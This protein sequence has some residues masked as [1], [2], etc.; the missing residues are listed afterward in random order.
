MKTATTNQTLNSL[1]LADKKAYE[2]YLKEV[3]I[4]YMPYLPLHLCVLHGDIR[5][6]KKYIAAGYDLNT[7]DVWGRTVVYYAIFNEDIK[8]LK[9]LIDSGADYHFVDSKV[10]RCTLVHLAATEGYLDKVKYLIETLG[11]NFDDIDNNNH[12]PLSSSM[13]FE[14]V[15]IAEYLIVQGAVNDYQIQRI[16]VLLI[17]LTNVLKKLNKQAEKRTVVPFEILDKIRKIKNFMASV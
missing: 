15:E 8:I 14:Q 9:L 6:I 2:H 11:L 12:T 5:K 7:P 13:L 17:H 4:E 3:K 1:I 16:D 10:S